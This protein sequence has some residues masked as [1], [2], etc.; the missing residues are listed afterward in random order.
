M[1]ENEEEAMKNKVFKISVILVMILTMTMTNFIF[2]GSTLISYAA[3]AQAT[4][5]KNVEFKA[6]FK[7]K[8]GR[9]ITTLEKEVN[10]EEAFLYLCIDV[11]KE[12]YFNGQIQLESS[13]F[14]LKETRKQLCKQNRK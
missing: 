9:E 6:Y 8:E 2:V 5:H 14:T 13:N 4:N 12:G 3:D 1:P 11:K 7:D 10:Q